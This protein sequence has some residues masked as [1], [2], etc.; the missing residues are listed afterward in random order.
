MFYQADKTEVWSPERS[1]SDNSETGLS[2]EGW[3]WGVRIYRRFFNKNEGGQN[4]R[5]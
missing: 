2:G 5:R 4:F 3:W 1:I